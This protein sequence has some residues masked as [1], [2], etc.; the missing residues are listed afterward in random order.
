MKV[1]QSC[2]TLFDPMNCSSSIHGILQAKSIGIGYHFLLWGLFLT[3]RS[4]LEP[5]SLVLQTDSL[6][7]SHQGSPGHK[8]FM[9]FCFTWYLMSELKLCHSLKNQQCI[10]TIFF[11]GI[12]QK[13]YFI[14]TRSAE[15][16]KNWSIIIVTILKKDNKMR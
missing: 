4:N 9:L 16:E 12:T 14:D 6:P 2:L 1:T 3:Q 10:L 8:Q 13:K 7:L 5:E 11:E 15:A